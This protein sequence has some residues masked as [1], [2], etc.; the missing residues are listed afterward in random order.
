MVPSLA[1]VNYMVHLLRGSGHET[2]GSRASLVGTR[3]THGSRSH[4]TSETNL[5][6]TCRNQ[7]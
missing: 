4:V 2:N 6:L 7:N 5:Y 3:L 1:K